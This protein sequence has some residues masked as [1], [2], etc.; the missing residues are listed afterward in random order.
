MSRHSNHVQVRGSAAQHTLEQHRGELRLRAVG[1]GAAAAAPTTLRALVH[2]IK[3]KLWEARP[4]MVPEIPAHVSLTG[5]GTSKALIVGR[6]HASGEGAA[7][8][9]GG[10]S[11]ARHR[12][13]QALITD[14]ELKHEVCSILWRSL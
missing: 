14:K 3:G 7:A 5:R 6:S 1:E 4:P 13:P 8:P 12:S 9:R 11:G 10:H 2:V